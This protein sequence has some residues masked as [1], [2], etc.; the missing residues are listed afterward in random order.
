MSRKGPAP[1]TSRSPGQGGK[2]IRAWVSR[3][4]YD[5]LVVVAGGPR[6]L[7]R[8]IR[9]RALDALTVAIVDRDERR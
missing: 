3:V 6:L 1:T 4:E 5:A 8:W 9:A 7:P 2:E